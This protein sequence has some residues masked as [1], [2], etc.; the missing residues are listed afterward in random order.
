M[1]RLVVV[2][3]LHDKIEHSRAMVQ[4][5]LDRKEDK[6]SLQVVK[7]LKKSD[8]RFRKQV[9]ELEEHACLC[10]VAIN[11]ARTLVVKEIKRSM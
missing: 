10:L 11:Q 8:V 6:F 2:A 7:E 9:E 4:L 5:C 1:G 3:R